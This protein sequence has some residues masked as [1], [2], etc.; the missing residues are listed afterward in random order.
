MVIVGFLCTNAVLADSYFICGFG[1]GTIF[2]EMFKNFFGTVQAFF[3]ELCYHLHRQ[4]VVMNGFDMAAK[5]TLPIKRHTSDSSVVSISIRM[6]AFFSS[7]R[8]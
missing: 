6:S 3:K 8:E 4:S 1:I 5:M 2:F 7:E